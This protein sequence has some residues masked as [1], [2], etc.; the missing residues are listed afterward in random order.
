[1][2]T[3]LFYCGECGAELK[4]EV[5]LR[6]HYITQHG[7]MYHRGHP[8]TAVSGEQLEKTRKRKMNSRQ[9]RRRREA[10]VEPG[11]EDWAYTR[12]MRVES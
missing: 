10:E 9:R 3:G 4:S 7:L 5:T 12:C 6:D 2:N 1:M 11:T 8:P